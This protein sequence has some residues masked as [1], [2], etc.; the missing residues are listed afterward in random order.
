MSW[1]LSWPPWKVEV[2]MRRGWHSCSEE[3]IILEASP[4]PS[5]R[6]V[7]SCGLGTELTCL[8]VQNRN[9][10]V[11]IWRCFKSQTLFWRWELINEP[12]SHLHKLH[13]EEYGI[14][15]QDVWQNSSRRQEQQMYFKEPRTNSPLGQFVNQ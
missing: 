6:L 3:S 10:R 15:L 8:R 13:S 1:D 12:L 14:R 2:T 5:P 7:R 11:I 9:T 4:A